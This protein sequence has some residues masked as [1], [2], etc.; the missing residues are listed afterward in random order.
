MRCP[1]CGSIDDKVL[2]T[3]QIAYGNSMRRRREC[4]SCGYRFTSYETIEEK[5]LMVVKRDDRRELFTLEKLSAGIQT[6]CEKRPVSQLIIDDL[7]HEV[8]ELCILEAAEKH[9]I[10]SSRIG[11]MVMEQLKNIDPVAY[12]RFASVYRNFENVLEFIK[13]IEKIKSI[14]I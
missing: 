10:S 5:K 11:D 13:E 3:R 2:E 1:S 14:N 6:A 7:L 8:E 9:E 4:L 12:I